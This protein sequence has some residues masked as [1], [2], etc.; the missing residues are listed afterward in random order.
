MIARLGECTH[1]L[2]NLGI[3]TQIMIWHKLGVGTRKAV[4]RDHFTC[5]R[6]RMGAMADKC[7]TRMGFGTAVAG[8]LCR[9]SRTS[10]ELDGAPAEPHALRTPRQT[11]VSASVEAFGVNT[12]HHAV[13][14]HCARGDRARVRGMQQVARTL[15]SHL[16]AQLFVARC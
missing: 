10:L 15:D 4:A 7:I 8:G 1:E 13:E 9:E 14:R 16:T 6:A 2:R 3:H 12:Q 11:L 5:L